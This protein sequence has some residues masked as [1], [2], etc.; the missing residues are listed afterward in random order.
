M[1]TRYFILLLMGVFAGP[2]L[3]QLG[4]GIGGTIVRTTPLYETRSPALNYVVPIELTVGM[5]LGRLPMYGSIG[6]RSGWYVHDYSILPYNWRWSYFLRLDAYPLLWT[7]GCNCPSF[8]SESLDI[9]RALYLFTAV[10]ATHQFQLMICGNGYQRLI[11]LEL[12]S[13]LRLLRLGKFSAA[14]EA[15]LSR[16]FPIEDDP[17]YAALHDGTLRLRLLYDF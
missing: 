10:G 4:F 8:G 11:Q 1:K 17:G 2:V 12:G 3:A 14:V 9:R 5:P 7:K 13:G 15:S 16:Y 6:V